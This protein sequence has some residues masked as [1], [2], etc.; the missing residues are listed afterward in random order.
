MDLKRATNFE[1]K[2]QG[3]CQNELCFPVPKARLQ[4]FVR[5]NAGKTWFNI[6]AFAGLAVVLLIVG[7][8]KE[9]VAEN[10][11]RTNSINSESAPPLS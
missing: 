7:T 10:G 4:E 11:E 6:I 8:R 1:L 3:V 9:P 2:P 5:K